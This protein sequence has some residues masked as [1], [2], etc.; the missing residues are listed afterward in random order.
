MGSNMRPYFV[1][2]RPTWVFR[3]V[4]I[5]LKSLKFFIN[6]SHFAFTLRDEFCSCNVVRIGKNNPLYYPL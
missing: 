5:S 2:K 3:L 4:S 1:C 6:F